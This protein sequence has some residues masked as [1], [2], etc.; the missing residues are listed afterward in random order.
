MVT[1]RSDFPWP[2]MA[3]SHLGW[4]RGRPVRFLRL[5]PLFLALILGLAWAADLRLN[6]SPSM[7]RGV[8]R[9]GPRPAG[10]PPRGIWVAACPPEASAALARVRG[11]V[12]LGDCAGGIQP[13]IKPVGAVPGDVVAVGPDGVQVNGVPLAHSPTASADS[14]GRPLPHVPWGT[15]IVPEGQVWLLATTHP[16]SWDSRYFGPVP[17]HAIRGTARAL[18][19]LP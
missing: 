14:Q 19:V 13:V 16:R 4:C 9:L 5:G 3:P 1:Y 8:Y 10:P 12:R 6:L 2:G 7:P 11:Y 18:L 15:R 17:L